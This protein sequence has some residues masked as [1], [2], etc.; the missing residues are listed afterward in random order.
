MLVLCL[1]DGL[2]CNEKVY[3]RGEVFILPDKL[4][5]EYGGLTPP[6]LARKHKSIYGFELFRFASE[7]DIWQAY[8]EDNTIMA[9]LESSEKHVIS[10]FLK[11]TAEKLTVAA[12]A[13]SPDEEKEEEK[14]VEPVVQ[15]SSDVEVKTPPKPETKKTPPRKPRKSSKKK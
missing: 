12:D 9:K 15:E 8:K 7:D 5:D 13:M 4:K 6:Q 11:S 2:T 10:R 14:K 3:E 1:R